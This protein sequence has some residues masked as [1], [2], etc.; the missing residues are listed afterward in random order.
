MQTHSTGIRNLDGTAYKAIKIAFPSIGEQQRIVRVL[1]EALAGI[2][3]AKSHSEKNLQNASS[4]FG[5]ELDLMFGK[6]SAGSDDTTIGAICELDQGLAINKK[7]KHLL[8]TNSS[9]PLLRIK[10]LRDNT[11]E[12]YVA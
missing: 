11:E 2:A 10:D 12:Q 4:L 5:N 3:T 6:Y 8:V 7:T 1:D 9:L